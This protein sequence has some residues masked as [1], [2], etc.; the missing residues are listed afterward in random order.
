VVSDQILVVLHPTCEDGRVTTPWQFGP[1]LGFDLE[2]TG[3]DRYHDVPVSYA[4]IEFNEGKK[5]GGATRIVNP[6]R[7]IPAEAM[8]VHGIT[9]ERA[10]AE[11]QPLDEAIAEI[12]AALVAATRDDVP[13]VGSNLPYDLSMIEACAKRELGYGLIDAGFNAPVVDVLVLDKVYAKYR[14]G[15][16]KLDVLCEVYGIAIDGAHD[17]AVDATAAVEVA[18]AQVA[19]FADVKNHR[20]EGSLPPLDQ[21]E[22]REL[23]RLQQ[24]WHRSWAESFTKFLSE[25]NLTP[26]TPDEFV[27]PLAT[28]DSR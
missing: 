28:P 5:V 14:K 4:L 19:L 21:V 11:G 22:V 27:W 13:V 24:Q 17:A 8:A 12:V 25:K 16:K 20:G 1:L 23:H 7:P 15:K 26:L 9:D 10:R 3:I 18:L 2:T 6:G